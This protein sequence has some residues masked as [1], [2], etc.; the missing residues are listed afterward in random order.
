MSTDPLYSFQCQSE[1]AHR[2]AGHRPTPFRSSSTERPYSGPR[3]GSVWDLCVSFSPIGLPPG[4]N[5]FTCTRHNRF[6]CGRPVSASVPSILSRH[7][8]PE[9]CF[10]E[11][12]TQELASKEVARHYYCVLRLRSLRTQIPSNAPVLIRGV[13]I[14]TPVRHIPQAQSANC[15]CF[16]FI[17]E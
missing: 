11:N 3:P 6:V 5:G 2:H 9:S 14:S 4:R 1:G 8:R 15:D 16:A 17:L 10:W 12:Q 7:M 13:F